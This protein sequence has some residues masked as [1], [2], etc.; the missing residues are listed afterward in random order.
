MSAFMCNDAH[1]DYLGTYAA[2]CRL[3]LYPQGGEARGEC[4]AEFGTDRP[5][6]THKGEAVAGILHA[7]NARSVEARYPSCVADNSMGTQDGYR[8]R[9]APHAVFT[10]ARVLAAVRCLRYQSCEV[11]GWESSLAYVVLEAIEANAL[12]ELTSG[13]PW[14]LDDDTVH[15]VSISRPVRSLTVMR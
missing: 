11:E 13:E 8:F 5:N 3:T 7:A 9:V 12:R 14:G 2:L 15:P 4:V 1:F 6:M 10:P